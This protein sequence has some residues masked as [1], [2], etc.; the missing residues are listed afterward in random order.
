MFLVD[1]LY[2]NKSFT[3]H[4]KLAINFMLHRDLESVLSLVVRDNSILRHNV[5]ILL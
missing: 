3:F 5:V 2:V 1:L 4:S